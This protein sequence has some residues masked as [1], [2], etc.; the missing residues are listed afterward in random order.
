MEHLIH[1]LKA[2]LE[3][4]LPGPEVQYL[5][6]PSLRKQTVIK[7]LRPEDYRLSAVMVLFCLDEENNWFIPL[8][9]RFAYGGVHSGQV[10]LPGG[11]FETED[12]TTEQ[13]ALRECYE[14]IGVREDIEIVGRLSPLFIPV[15]G[16]L[17]EPWVGISRKKTPVFTLNEREVKSIIRLNVKDLLDNSIMK[18]GNIELPGREVGLKIKTPWFEAGGYKIWGATAMMLNELKAVVGPIF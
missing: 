12:V 3:K 5:M 2:E 8:T 13:T 18:T 7:D 1:T 9:E 17:V 11:K 15:S 14:E 10:S 6:A 16:F 4:T